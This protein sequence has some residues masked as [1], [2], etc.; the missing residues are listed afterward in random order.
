LTIKKIDQLNKY[1]NI[2]TIKTVNDQYF[3]YWLAGFFDG[4][5]YV[6]LDRNVIRISQKEDAV[7]KLIK[8]R[9]NGNLYLDKSWNGYCLEWGRKADVLLIT[10]LLVNKT[11]VKRPA[12]ITVHKALKT[13]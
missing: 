7:L 11:Y 2:Q 4:E 5:G 9:Y 10:E 3:S 8:A 1:Y 6:N 13:K 12:L